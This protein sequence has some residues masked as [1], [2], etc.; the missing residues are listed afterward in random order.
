[1]F[2]ETIIV[3]SLAIGI[4]VGVGL[5]AGIGQLLMNQLDFSGEGYKAFYI[6]SMTITCIFFFVLFGL[7]VIM[8]SMK[9]SRISV[10]Q[11]VHADSQ[12]ERDEVKEKMTA[13]VAFLGFLLLGI[14]YNIT[15][16]VGTYM[17]FGSLLPVMME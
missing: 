4:A 16:T 5:A 14:G 3:A 11:L 6:P 13:V 10:L 7:S 12:T 1:M 8:N 17:L 15:A 2:I 9:L